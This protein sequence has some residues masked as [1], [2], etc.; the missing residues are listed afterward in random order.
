MRASFPSQVFQISVIRT[1][2]FRDYRVTATNLRLL[3]QRMDP[4][5]SSN[6][7]IRMID[8]AAVYADVI[9]TTQGRDHVLV[10]FIILVME[11]MPDLLVH[12]HL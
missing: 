10:D 8:E 1:V 9:V 2:F 7:S 6:G 11:R 4:G 12:S 5:L 3:M